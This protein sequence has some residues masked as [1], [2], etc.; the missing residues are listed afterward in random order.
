MREEECV[1]KDDYVSGFGHGRGR[2]LDPRLSTPARGAY[3]ISSPAFC[4]TR[5]L[6]PVSPTHAPG[7]AASA[8]SPTVISDLNDPA[9][10][11]LITH[12][13]Q[14][15]GQT[16]MSAQLKGVGEEKKSSGTHN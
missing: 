15:V 9:L 1:P 10:N 2:Y 11:N 14:T 16:M 8:L 13:A 3:N 12:I 7:G 5:L 6:G 4:S